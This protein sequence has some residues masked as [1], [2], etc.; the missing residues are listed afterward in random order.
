MA[1][2]RAL[3]FDFDNVLALTHTHIEQALENLFMHEFSL[4]ADQARALRQEGAATG[5]SATYAAKRHSRGHRWIEQVYHQLGQVYSTSYLQA[6]PPC[7]HIPGL[8][9]TALEQDYELAILSQ[10][11]RSPIISILK[12]HD[13]LGYLPENRIFDRSRLAGRYDKRT[14]APYMALMEAL[15]LRSGDDLTMFEDVPA[16]LPAAHTLGWR[17]VLVGTPVRITR[18]EENR[19]HEY[20]PDIQTALRHRLGVALAA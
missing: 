3:I 12:G 10:A 2:R 17:T 8:L 16:N 18:R 5:C 13:L 7:V 1:T 19:I 9:M 4:T 11:H 6:T 14:T 20:H 15:D